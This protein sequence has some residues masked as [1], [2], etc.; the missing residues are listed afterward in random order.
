MPQDISPP[1]SAQIPDSREQTTSTYV[2]FCAF[3]AIIGGFNA[4]YNAGVPNISQDTII[5]CTPN[6]NSS[7]YFPDCLPMTPWTW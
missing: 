5:N 6:P 2:L 1:S 4:G 3:T 7:S